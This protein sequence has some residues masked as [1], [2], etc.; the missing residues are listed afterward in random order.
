MESKNNRVYCYGMVARGLIHLLEMP[1]PKANSYAEIGETIENIAGE[2]VAGA[3]VLQQLGVDT[4]LDGRWLSD[5]D[6]S[7]NL[8]ESLKA[9]GI[10]SSRLRIEPDYKPVEEVVIAD[11]VTRTVFGGYRK[12]LFT[13]RQWNIPCEEDIKDASMVLLDPFLGAE[14][15]QCAMLCVKHCIPYITCDV[16]PD[17]YIA[18]HAYAT[19]ISDEFLNRETTAILT[20]INSEVDLDTAQVLKVVYQEY[21]KQCSGWVVFTFGG[22]QLWY[23]LPTVED[24]KRERHGFS[25]FSVKVVDTTG[26]GDSFRAGFAYAVLHNKNKHEVLEWASAVAGLCCERFPGVLNAPDKI[27]VE[28]FLK[29][30]PV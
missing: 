4:T 18:E 30:N 26:A 17:S 24:D 6:S 20:R 15:I 3:W 23:T 7:R 19:L 1:Y 22:D 25:P 8:L 16:E 28:E 27:Q 13:E 21:I 12:I 2:A 9:H 11:G 14:S 29:R 5:T 10:N